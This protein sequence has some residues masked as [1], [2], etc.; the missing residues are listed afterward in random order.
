MTRGPLP[1]T[2]VAAAS[3]AAA[4]D[5]GGWQWSALFKLLQ[6]VFE[7]LPPLARIAVAQQVQTWAMKAEQDAKEE[8]TGQVFRAQGVRDTTGHTRA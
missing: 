1:R 6:T 7:A 5:P 4:A 2:A 8:M 3:G